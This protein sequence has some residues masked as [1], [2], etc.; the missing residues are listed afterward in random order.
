MSKP[1]MHTNSN[2][3]FKKENRNYPNQGTPNNRDDKRNSGNFNNHNNAN[4]NNASNNQNANKGNR[5]E[6]R[7]NQTPP[8]P[9]KETETP[10]KIDVKDSKDIV[11]DTATTTATEKKFTGRCRLFVGN[12]TPD[13]TEEEFK[14]LFE[15]H[16]EFS[17]V[18]VNNSRGFGFIRLDYRHNAEAAKAALDGLQR[19]GRVLRV[20][21]ATHGAALKVKN[22]HCHVSNEL[23]DQ[24][25][26]QFGDI[27]RC[28]VIVD[29]RGKS[30]GEGIVEFARKPGANSALRRI[31]EGVF[32]MGAD[33]RPVAVEP[34]EQK[35]EEDGMPEKFLMKTGEYK[36]ERE[37]DPRFAPPG[38][39]EYEFGMRWKQLE[40]LEK[41]RIEQVKKDTEEGKEK[42]ENEMQDALIE[43][44]AEQ[45]RQN[46]ARQQEELRRLEEHRNVDRQRRQEQM[47]IRR[48]ENDRDRAQAEERRRADMMMSMRQQ[49]MSR[50][51]GPMDPSMRQRE[52]MMMADRFSDR[53]ADRMGDRMGDRPFDRTNDRMGG[54]P[55]GMMWQDDKSRGEG[56]MRGEPH[57]GRDMRGSGAQPL[58]P[59][60]IPPQGAMDRGGPVAAAAAAVAASQNSKSSPGPK[61]LMQSGPGFS[62]AS[63][64]GGPNNPPDNQMRG[65]R[66]EQG[67]GDGSFQNQRGVLGSAPG[68]PLGP[69]MGGPQGGPIG[70]GANSAAAMAANQMRGGPGGMGGP[71]GSPNM[72]GGQPGGMN[73]RMLMDRRR[74]A[75]R[76]ELIDIKR[77]RRM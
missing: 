3:Q 53:M 73:E 46:L 23:L 25:F 74:E 47:E 7:P 5:N 77:M 44:Q 69:G 12:L 70:P 18:Y 33:P 1:G 19:K 45:I 64:A 38:T 2:N 68:V 51:R 8:T 43:F 67:R 61:P 56:L 35:D 41:Q 24:S 72:F 32:L 28:I 6:Q 10:E 57:R 42:L 17:E 13:I 75:A 30:T 16:G 22:L 37:K 62:G 36:K 14:K 9:K 31:T 50:G 52:E 49:D 27:E 21:F 60:P 54:Q 34:L 11:I 71:G 63:G 20:R 66:F 29:D 4:A 55:S 65:S 48:Q 76:E 15:P 59:P 40:E 26:S 39:F 58:Q